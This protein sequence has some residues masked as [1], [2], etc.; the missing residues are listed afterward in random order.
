M[1]AVDNSL[2]IVAKQEPGLNV[3]CCRLPLQAE[4]GYKHTAK[5]EVARADLDAHGAFASDGVD[6]DTA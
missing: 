5:S 1:Y 6:L 2:K 3:A 4:A